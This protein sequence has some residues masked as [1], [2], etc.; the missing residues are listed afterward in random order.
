VKAAAHAIATYARD[1]NGI[2]RGVARPKLAKKQI[3]HD[4]RRHSACGHALNSI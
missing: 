4:Q 1:L 2:P 3:S